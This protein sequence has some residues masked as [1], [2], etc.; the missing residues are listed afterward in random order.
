MKGNGCTGMGEAGVYEVKGSCGDDRF[1]GVTV[2]QDRLHIGIQTLTH[3]HV[4]WGSA[5]GGIL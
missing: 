1:G 2:I 5:A 3:R 4:T